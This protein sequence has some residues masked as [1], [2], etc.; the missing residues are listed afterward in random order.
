MTAHRSYLGLGA[1]LGDAA[2]AVRRAFDALETIGD[3]A[4]R[5]SLYRTRPWG[6]PYQ[7]DFVNAVALLETEL[8]PL[9]LLVAVKEM[10]KRLGR[11]AGERW[12]PRSID[13]DVLTYDDLDIDVPGLRVPH[14]HL[15]QR[16]FVLVPLAEIDVRYE[17]LRAALPAGELA[18]VARME[19]RPGSGDQD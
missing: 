18:G 16:A 11:V 7:P 8:P 15:R 3:V 5:S 17:A 12:G 10:E 19:S 6:N 1:N 2:A 14:H 9:E 13:I 4:A